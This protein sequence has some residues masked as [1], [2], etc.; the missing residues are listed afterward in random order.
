MTGSFWLF[1]VVAIAK[2]W[3]TAAVHY[4]LFD[5]PGVKTCLQSQ[6]YEGRTFYVDLSKV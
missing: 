1:V 5:T 4:L 2:H 6:T 3:W